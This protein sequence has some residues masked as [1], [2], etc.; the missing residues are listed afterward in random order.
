MIEHCLICFNKLKL[1]V[2]W[3]TIFS[4]EDP[5]PI[6]KAC[7]A[8][9][10]KIEGETCVKCDRPL[11]GIDP[12]F[13]V[14]D[15]CLDCVRWE[16]DKKWSEVLSKNYSAVTYNDFA[17]EVIARYKYRGDYI[18]AHA[19]GY[20]LKKKLSLIEFDTIIPIP[21][22][23]TRQYERGF[24]Q[25]EALIH[26]CGYEARPLLT[27]SHSEKQSK[28]SRLERIHLPQVF[29]IE[30]GISNQNTLL[31]DDIYTTGSTLRHAAKILKEAGVA[32]VCSLTF[33]R[34]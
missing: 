10:T 25:S 7:E 2:G 33:A 6:C 31:I 32:S 24:N 3:T 17:Q 19:I 1:E 22:S 8:K 21:L 15:H 13:N 5:P 18:L 28:K 29:Q 14:N 23:K 9:F 12:K 4:K 30:S 16:E 20:L 11:A 26:A 34:G 27:R